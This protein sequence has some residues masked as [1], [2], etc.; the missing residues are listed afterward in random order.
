[1]NFSSLLLYTLFMCCFNF[2]ILLFVFNLY[3]YPRLFSFCSHIPRL[4]SSTN[5]LHTV[6]EVPCTTTQIFESRQVTAGTYQ[7]QRNHAARLSHS[8][9]EAIP[10]YINQ[11]VIRSV[12][13]LP[14]GTLYF[15]NLTSPPGHAS[16]R[17]LI[18]LV[19]VHS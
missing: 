12:S 5:R 4:L 16:G 17:D 8:V 2:S 13:Y 11:P 7:Y 1:M 14:F 6:Y 18:K 15:R 19:K 3:I 9:R 10:G